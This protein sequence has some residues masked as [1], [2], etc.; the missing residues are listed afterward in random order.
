MIG[1]V[2]DAGAQGNQVWTNA[3]LDIAHSRTCDCVLCVFRCGN[4]GMKRPCFRKI[5][6]RNFLHFRAF[7]LF[8]ET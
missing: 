8:Y 7:G 6:K 5:D 1:L 3:Q 4:A 2:T